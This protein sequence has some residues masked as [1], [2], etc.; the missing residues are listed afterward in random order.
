MDPDAKVQVATLGTA[1]YFITGTKQS[2]LDPIDS[3]T[4]PVDSQ[5]EITG[6]TRVYGLASTPDFGGEPNTIDSTT[7]DNTEY[8]TNVLGLQP[9]NVLSY[10]INVMDF[11]VNT[12]ANHNL[13]LINNLV[14]D[15]TIARWVVDKASGVRL[16]YD[17]ITKIQYNADEQ[18]AI[19]KFTIF[20]SLKS[21]IKVSIPTPSGS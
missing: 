12:A 17:A 4:I 7:L 15:K 8:E 14:K 9:S 10:E 21:K 16:Y 13:Y 20:H 19:E 3:W 6:M 18:S 2:P 1:L 11:T 5:G